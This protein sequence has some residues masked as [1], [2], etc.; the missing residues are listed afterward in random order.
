MSAL[1]DQREQPTAPDD[2]RHFN[3]QQQQK[4]GNA[5]RYTR[6]GILPNVTARTTDIGIIMLVFCARETTGRG[7]A[8]VSP[9]SSYTK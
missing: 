2:R 8:R 1:G 7:P 5:D 4:T 3:L 9:R 6:Q